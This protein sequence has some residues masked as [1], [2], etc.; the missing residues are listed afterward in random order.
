MQKDLSVE[1]GFSVVYFY[2]SGIVEKKVK[3]P[4][5]HQLSPVKLDCQGYYLDPFH[6]DDVSPTMVVSLS[7]EN[8]F[9]SSCEYPFLPD[10]FGES[11][12]GNSY[13]ISMSRHTPLTSLGRA[14]RS[15]LRG[16]CLNIN[17][18]NLDGIIHGD[19]KPDNL[20]YDGEKILLID[21]G[22]CNF[23]PSSRYFDFSKVNF[24]NFF[25]MS[26]SYAPP[27][28][29]LGK[30]IE[31]DIYQTALTCFS[32]LTGYVRR[33]TRDLPSTQEILSEILGNGSHQAIHYGLHDSPSQRNIEP[34]IEY[35][36]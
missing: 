11:L 28:Q 9:Y 17:Q 3:L 6:Y 10:Y 15:L 18:L 2:P 5:K 14:E 26:K 27:E 4:F 19:I 33:D 12:E 35:L 23:L 25:S 16:L 13:S 30:K 8:T 32:L 22:N 31:N 29:F 34:L 36:S 7:R 1:G 20:V 21:F 24:D